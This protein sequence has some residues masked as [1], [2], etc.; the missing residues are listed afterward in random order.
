M[1]RSCKKQPSSFHFGMNSGLISGLWHFECL[2]INVSRRTLISIFERTPDKLLNEVILFDDGN[3]AIYNAQVPLS[4]L[5][6]P[7]SH[8]KV[9]NRPVQDTQRIR[10]LMRNWSKTACSSFLKHILR[11]F[12]IGLN[13]YDDPDLVALPIHDRIIE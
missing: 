1:N 6:N 11:S 12:P 9:E 8:F 5:L 13:P 7:F 10:T 4:L 3:R 2:R